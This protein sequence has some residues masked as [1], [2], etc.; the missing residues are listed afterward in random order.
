MQGALT[1]TTSG[2]CNAGSQCLRVCITTWQVT[3]LQQ[4][5]CARQAML[6]GNQGVG[7]LWGRRQRDVVQRPVIARAEPVAA[8]RRECLGPCDIDLS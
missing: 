2:G 8:P 5:V 7:T 1:R 6:C 4:V 3:S